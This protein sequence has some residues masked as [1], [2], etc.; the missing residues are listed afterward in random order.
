M[1]RFWC[2]RRQ[3][4]VGWSVT[5][6]GAGKRPF[7]IW[8]GPDQGSSS[9]QPEQQSAILISIPTTWCVFQPPLLGTVR[10]L[11]RQN[12]DRSQH[13]CHLQHGRRISTAANIPAVDA[14]RFAKPLRR[15]PT[16]QILAQ[17]P[18]AR[19]LAVQPGFLVRLPGLN[20]LHSKGQPRRCQ[21]VHSAGAGAVR[22]RQTSRCDLAVPAAPPSS[23]LDQHDGTVVLAAP[24]PYGLMQQPVAGLLGVPAL[25]GHLALRKVNSVLR[26][27]D[28]C[29]VARRAQ[30]Q[31]TRH[32]AGCC[33]RGNQ[34]PD[35]R[36][37]RAKHAAGMDAAAFAVAVWCTWVRHR[38]AFALPRQQQD[39]P[40]HTHAGLKTPQP[41]AQHRSA[42]QKPSQASSRKASRGPSWKAWMSGRALM[43]LLLNCRSPKARDTSMRPA[44]Q[45]ARAAQAS[46]VGQAGTASLRRRA[47][48]QA[49]AASAAGQDSIVERQLPPKGESMGV[50]PGQARSGDCTQLR[51]SR[52]ACLPAVRRRSQ[53]CPP[54]RCAAARQGRPACA[55]G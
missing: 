21:F 32:S 55:P 3:G 13:S 4:G 28:A 50:G 42:P 46:W 44:G 19:L 49:G 47:G 39:T 1:H 9:G 12:T 14:A 40:N 45:R 43:P 10:N 27:E 7:A 37:N 41:P 2:W 33:G 20:Q 51:F 30:R 17:R 53:S 6:I 5:G 23:D 38:R 54:S 24:L 16:A 34:Q 26:G 22:T 15:H 18:A 48:T 25:E 36:T 11:C 31:A 8:H 52:A 35:S 29:G